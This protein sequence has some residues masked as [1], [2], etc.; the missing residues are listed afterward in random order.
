MSVAD[1]LGYDLKCETRQLGP[2]NTSRWLRYVGK[3][4]KTSTKSHEA[5]RTLFTVCR[6]NR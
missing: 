5:A 3:I 6:K 2:V 1:R 4:H